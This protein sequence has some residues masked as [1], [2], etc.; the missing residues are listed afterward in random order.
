[1]SG[2][3]AG[4]H[5]RTCTPPR[6]RTGSAEDRATLQDEDCAFAAG[7]RPEGGPR[8]AT[9]MDLVTSKRDCPPEAARNADLDSPHLWIS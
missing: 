3:R 5:A 1:M 7:S 4:G 9:L 2:A 8:L 6:L